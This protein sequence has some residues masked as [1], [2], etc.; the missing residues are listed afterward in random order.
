MDHSKAVRNWFGASG[1][2]TSLRLGWMNLS[3]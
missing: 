1:A 2:T 3:T